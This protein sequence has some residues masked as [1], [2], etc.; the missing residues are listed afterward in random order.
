MLL[1]QDEYLSVEHLLLGLAAEDAKFMRPALQR[2]GVS[3]NKIKE[4]VVEVRGKKRVN[5]KNP[6]V[7][8]SPASSLRLLRVI[9]CFRTA[10]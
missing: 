3:F 7:V 1:L 9:S 2:Q 10:R 4:A 6:E 5:S 8:R